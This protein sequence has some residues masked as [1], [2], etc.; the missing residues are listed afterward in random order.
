M[1]TD[2]RWRMWTA[3]AVQFLVLLALIGVKQYTLLSGTPVR[4]E[5]VPVDPRDL[6]RGD[7]VVLDYRISDLDLSG[8]DS[9]ESRPFEEHDTVFVVL[10]PDGEYWTA[11]GAYHARPPVD[12]GQVVLRGEVEYTLEFR[13]AGESSIRVKYGIESYFVP[14][15]SGWAIEQIRGRGL[16]AE[17]VVDRFGNGVVRR[18]LVD[19]QPLDVAVPGVVQPGRP[20]A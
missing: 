1:L 17:V 19:G 13:V 6:F 8:L 4:L 16:G 3:V 7:Y 20:S 10:R 15:G 14:E 18:L 2:I 12:A 11:A 9:D 5:T